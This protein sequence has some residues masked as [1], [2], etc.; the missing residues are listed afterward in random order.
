MILLTV[1]VSGFL[2]SI[3]RFYLSKTIGESWDKPFPLGTFLIN[4]SGSLI[5]GFL[6]TI[7]AR[8]MYL[9]SEIKTGITVGFVGAYTTFSTFSYESLQL[10]NDREWLN[11]FL[12]LG[13]SLGVSLLMTAFGIS[14]A[15]L[16]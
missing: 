15:K 5:L 11:S 10:I 16:F 13:L 1:F 8:E 6:L 2:G 7:L 4:V 12:Y 9:P 3:L 14:L